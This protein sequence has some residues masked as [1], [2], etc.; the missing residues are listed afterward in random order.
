MNLLTVKETAEILRVS[1]LTVRRYISRNMLHAVHV[2]RGIRIQR[3]ELEDF[4]A[5]KKSTYFNS[6]GTDENDPSTWRPMT[7]DDP[8]WD[9]VGIIKDGPPDLAQNHDAYLAEAYED[10]HR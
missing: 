1:P 4:V 3:E 6:P 7:E 10:K 2:G 9:I 5:P 8:I